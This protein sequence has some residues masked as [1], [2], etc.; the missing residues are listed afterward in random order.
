[1]KTTT[2]TKK[3]QPQQEFMHQQ[4][5]RGKQTERPSWANSRYLHIYHQYV[6]CNSISELGLLVMAVL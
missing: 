4:D 1:M 6:Y 2:K 3:A 5:S